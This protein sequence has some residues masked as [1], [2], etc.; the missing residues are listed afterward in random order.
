MKKNY[1]KPQTSVYTL[2]AQ[3]TL[4]QGSPVTVAVEEDED[5]PIEDSYVREDRGLWDEAW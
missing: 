5:I 1:I 3:E 2:V 4:M